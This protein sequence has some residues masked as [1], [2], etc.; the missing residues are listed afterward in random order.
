MIHH[1]PANVNWNLSVMDAETRWRLHAVAITNEKAADSVPCR[2]E[3]GIPTCRT[4]SSPARTPTWSRTWCRI[5]E[6]IG[7]EVATP[8][9]ARQITGLNAMAE[10][11]AAR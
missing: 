6:T 9:E 4:A 8:E 5:A 7:R 10:A 3:D 2:W 11:R 1:M